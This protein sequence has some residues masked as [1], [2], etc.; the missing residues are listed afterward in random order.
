MEE[1]FKQR[2][3]EELQHCGLTK[4]EFAKKIGVSPEMITQYYTT[5]KLPKL[6]TFTK[7]CKVLGVSADYLLGLTD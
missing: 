3:Y 5:K 2:F 4:T 7:I 1:K 6:D